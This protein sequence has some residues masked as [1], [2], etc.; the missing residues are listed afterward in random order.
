MVEHQIKPLQGSL[1]C[2]DSS[3]LT[4]LFGKDVATMKFG[5]CTSA[6]IANATAAATNK[7]LSR[8]NRVLNVVKFKFVSPH[9]KTTSWQSKEQL[10]SKSTPPESETTITRAPAGATANET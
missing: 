8:Q 3:D 9:V 4:A 7:K 10:P 1:Q 2:E 5:D 6:F